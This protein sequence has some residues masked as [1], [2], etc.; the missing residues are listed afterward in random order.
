MSK[1][2]TV[3]VTIAYMQGANDREAFKNEIDLLADINALLSVHKELMDHHDHVKPAVTHNG[4]ES[5]G[6]NLTLVFP[7]RHT[8]TNQYQFAR[9]HYILQELAAILAKYQSKFVRLE[10]YLDNG[11]M[12]D[13]WAM[14]AGPAQVLLRKGA[15]QWNATGDDI[16]SWDGHFNSPLNGLTVMG[17]PTAV[18]KFRR[19][20]QYYARSH[21]GRIAA[22]RESMFK[23]GVGTGARINIKQMMRS[24]PNI[25]WHNLLVWVHVQNPAGGNWVVSN[26][27]ESNRWVVEGVRYV[28][29]NMK[30]MME[31][32]LPF[33]S[34]R[35]NSAIDTT[36]MRF[37]KTMEYATFETQEET[38]YDG[39][40]LAIEDETVGEVAEV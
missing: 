14:V 11:G 6:C 8:G 18:D 10:S 31:T 24:H 28:N 26:L 9:L 40:A 27:D 37:F 1:P 7:I 25:Q 17:E 30:N 12:P 15:E 22:E 19:V 32:P 36:D 20:W 4:N 34:L 23:A 16:P 2:N 38:V 5:Y 21:A 13:P 3:S 33:T 39:T 29:I 35:W